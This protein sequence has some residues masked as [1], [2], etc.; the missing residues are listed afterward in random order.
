MEPFKRLRSRWSSG[1]KRSA[2]QEDQEQVA[3]NTKSLLQALGSTFLRE[4]R[5]STGA[6]HSPSTP[7][8]IQLNPTERPKGLTVLKNFATCD[9][10]ACS[11]DRRVE[12]VTKDFPFGISKL[13]GYFS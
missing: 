6:G 3:Y 8:T 2:S 1:S 5:K 7:A 9:I 13:F 4:Q 12:Y 11:W 10:P